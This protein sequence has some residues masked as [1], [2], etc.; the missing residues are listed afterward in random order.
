MK[1][2]I[3]FQQTDI[4]DLSYFIIKTRSAVLEISCESLWQFVQYRTL[5]IVYRTESIVYVWA[6]D[7]F[8]VVRKALFLKIFV[9]MRLLLLYMFVMDVDEIL[10]QCSL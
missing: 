10:K 3:T 9:I 5:Y 8:L 4:G 1:N 6:H 2:V 7:V